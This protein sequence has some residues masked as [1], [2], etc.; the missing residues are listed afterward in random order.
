M[1]LQPMCCSKS[2]TVIN[3][4]L[5]LTLFEKDADKVIAGQKLKFQINNESEEHEAMITQTGRSVTNDK[6][7]LV[8]AA[9]K[10]GV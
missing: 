3:C 10:R 4:L 1:L 8:Y 5:E 9:V 7:L 6:T 2:L